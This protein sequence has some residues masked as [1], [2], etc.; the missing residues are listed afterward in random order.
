MH[1]WLL[2]A[3]SFAICLLAEWWFKITC[4]KSFWLPISAILCHLSIPFWTNSDLILNKECFQPVGL[5]IFSPQLE[6]GRSWIMNDLSISK[7]KGHINI[8]QGKIEQFNRMKH[9]MM[10]WEGFSRDP[11]FDW[12]EICSWLW[13]CHVILY[14][15]WLGTLFVDA[16]SCFLSLKFCFRHGSFRSRMSPS[17]HELFT[18]RHAMVRSRFDKISWQ[19]TSHNSCE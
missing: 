11:K 9:T 12:D 5:C 16:A 2:W 15:T 17:C 1:C 8:G 13:T 18:R 14:Q 6:R 7:T 19:Q 3:H 10:L 4:A